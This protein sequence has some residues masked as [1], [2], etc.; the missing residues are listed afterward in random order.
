MTHF[1]FGKSGKEN[2]IQPF[3]G[4]FKSASLHLSLTLTFQALA[5]TVA[6]HLQSNSTDL[7]VYERLRSHLDGLPFATTPVKLVPSEEIDG[8]GTQ[9]WNL[10]TTVQRSEGLD[11]KTTALV[12]IFSFF[13]LDTG[14]Q[15]LR[16]R[17]TASVARILRVALKTAK[18]CMSQG[19][20][21]FSLKALER[22]AH[23]EAQ[24]PIPKTQG[25]KEEND[26]L[27]KLRAE[28]Y[29]LRTA[30]V[31]SNLVFSS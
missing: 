16:P 3:L 29:Q 10:S 31:G 17:T 1:A 8:I 30:L 26:E 4:V 6:D 18:Y 21:D 13:L 20:L 24:L 27:Q 15:T 28:Y 14:Q 22:A 2:K 7:T 12:K 5:Q 25:T 23:Y 9:L 11:G 19:E